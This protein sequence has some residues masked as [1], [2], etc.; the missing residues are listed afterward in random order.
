M[1]LVPTILGSEDF[2]AFTIRVKTVNATY[3]TK[4]MVLVLKGYQYNH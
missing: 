1:G 2:L 3:C 4:N